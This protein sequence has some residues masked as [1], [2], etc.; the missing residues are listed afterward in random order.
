[1]IWDWKYMY[2]KNRIWATVARKSQFNKALR[3]IEL[4]EEP[5]GLSNDLLRKSHF[6]QNI[7]SFSLNSYGYSPQ[8]IENSVSNWLPLAMIA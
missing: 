8:T 3:G 4:T 6:G 1:V 2:S 7:R 5:V